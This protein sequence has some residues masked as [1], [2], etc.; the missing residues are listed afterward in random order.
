[1]DK[2]C[3]SLVKILHLK[4]CFKNYVKINEERDSFKQKENKII[5][6]QKSSTNDY[7]FQG[8]FTK[9]ENYDLFKEFINIPLVK[10]FI[11][12]VFR[13]NKEIK[14][15]QLEKIKGIYKKIK[16]LLYK[17]FNRLNI[18]L[19]IPEDKYSFSCL[20]FGIKGNPPTNSDL[21]CYTPLLFM[22]FWI[23]G[24]SFIKK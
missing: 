9:L 21:D 3:S 1:M 2:F 11:E 18:E 10:I 13:P 7:N 4:K 23:Y 14:S 22:E 20:F 24:K 17:L 19:I 8:D 5:I 12:E 6:L 15:F 16:N